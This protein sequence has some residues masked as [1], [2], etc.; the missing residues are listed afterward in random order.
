MAR[1]TLSILSLF[2]GL[3][4]ARYIVPGGRWRD[5]DGNLVNAHAGCVTVDEETG[6]FWLFG[7][8]KI[9]GQ[10][11]GG[12]VSAYSSDDLATW[13]SHDLALS[14]SLHSTFSSSLLTA[15][16]APIEGHPYISTDHIIQRPKVVYSEVSN[17][18]HVR[19]SPPISGIK[20]GC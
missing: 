4:A 9:E 5:T 11:E 10:V 13:E 16:A 19:L 18:Y 1:L 20:R 6:K 17:E 15:C 3:S 14:L 8:Y 12:G 2:A 7:E